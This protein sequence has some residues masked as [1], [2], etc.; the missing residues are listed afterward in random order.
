MENQRRQRKREMTPEE[1]QIRKQKLF[2][3]RSSKIYIKM[4]GIFPGISY[5]CLCLQLICLEAKIRNTPS[6]KTG[7]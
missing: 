7:C 4:A 6:L 3:H 5:C 2:Y 1:R